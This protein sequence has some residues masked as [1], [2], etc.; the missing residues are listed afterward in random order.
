MRYYIF[1]VQHNAEKDSENRNAPK[2]FDSRHDAVKAYHAAIAADM[3][4]T[5]LDWSI[6]MLINSAMGVEMAE[7]WARE[8]APATE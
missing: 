2:A 7:K 3:G 1:S 5:S 6:T 4:N 8:E